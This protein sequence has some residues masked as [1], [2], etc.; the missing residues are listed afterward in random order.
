MSANVDGMVRAGVEAYRAG[1]K[2][3]ARQ[4]LERALELDEYNETAWLWL[5]AVVETKEEQQTCLENVLIIN[6]NNE[7]AKQGLRSLG[8]DPDALIAETQP[9]PDV[10]FSNEGFSGA[11]FMDEVDAAAPATDDPYYVPTS[12]ISS[13]HEG[14]NLT[15]EDYDQWMSQLDLGTTSDH[16]PAPQAYEADHADMGADTGDY[17]DMASSLFGDDV[18]YDEYDVY[19]STSGEPPSAAPQPRQAAYDDDPDDLVAGYDETDAFSEVIREGIHDVDHSDLFDEKPT[20]PPAAPEPSLDDI[21]A[22]IPAEIAATRLPGIRESV[23][24]SVY[25]VTVV[26]VVLNLGAVAFLVMQLA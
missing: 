8:V 9:E 18:D 26:L 10:G 14:E 4:L 5:S 19:G 7:R 20:P 12:S 3:E 16:V 13:Q 22:Q 24:A 15:S 21:F 6:P 1:N 23:P 25:I 11:D 17:S 2:I